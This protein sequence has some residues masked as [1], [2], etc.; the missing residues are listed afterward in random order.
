[1]TQLLLPI[2]TGLSLGALLF[3][4]AA[5]LTVVFG[6]MHVVN[7]GHGAFLMLG[8]YA[9]FTLTG[10]SAVSPITFV[11][12][13]VV[14]ALL[15]GL[16]GGIVEAG[17]L[18]RT[19]SGFYLNSLVLTF[20][21]LLLLEGIAVEVWGVNPQS[22]MYPTGLA[23]GTEILGVTVPLFSGI[24]TVVGIAVA[25]LLWII[26]ARTPIGMVIRAAAHDR[27]MTEALGV[28]VPRIYTGVFA[29]GMMLAGLAGGLASPSYSLSPEMGAIF[30]VQVFAVVVV[31]G[32]GSVSGAFIAAMVLG[33]IDALLSVYV[34]VLVGITFFVAMAIVL[35]IR[36][37]GLVRGW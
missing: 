32:M 7:F 13:L 6:V 16:L 28:N 1:M 27:D 22:Q 4:A 31:G 3:I 14:G 33:V 29:F 36:P 18:R 25:I 15:V 26:L 9:V 24:I 2:S 19:Y 12:V 23:R 35:L 10:G 5:G 8:A 17:L 20:G 11:V 34:P 21:V 30:I 37:Q